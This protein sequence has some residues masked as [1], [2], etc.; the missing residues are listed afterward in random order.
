MPNFIST[1]SAG[2]QNVDS[3]TIPVPPGVADGDLLYVVV[4][5][6]DTVVGGITAPVGWTP[7]VS[8]G[9]DAFSSVSYYRIANSEPANY[10]WTF[11]TIMNRFYAGAIAA[12]RS[13]SVLRA[14]SGKQVPQN[15][16]LVPATNSIAVEQ[17]DWIITAFVGNSGSGAMSPPAGETERLQF[18]Y[19]PL[20]IEINDEVATVSGASGAKQATSTVECQFNAEISAWKGQVRR[21][22]QTWQC[23]VG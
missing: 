8:I 22:N 6:Y 17:G 16:S 21:R 14:A 7:L 15:E 1:S 13:L 5:F 18:A 23:I 4:G 20:I 12:Y 9:Q 3:L 2:A 10:T 11:T 19:G